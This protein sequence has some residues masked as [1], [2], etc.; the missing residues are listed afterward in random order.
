MKRRVLF[1]TPGCFD[2][3]GISRYCR[4]QIQ[5]LR[6][7]HGTNSVRVL[8]LLGPGENDFEVPF[9]V[10]WSGS[11]APATRRDRVAFTVRAIWTSLMWRPQVVHCAH[12]N[13][14]PLANSLARLSRAETVLNVY[15]LE[16]WSGLSRRRARAMEAFNRVIADCYATADHVVEHGLHDERPTVIWDCADLDRFSPG[17]WSPDVAARYGV[18]ANKEIKVVLFLGRISEASRH[19]GA[20][21]LIAV[22]PRIRRALGAV[23]L[24]MA[25]AGDDKDRLEREVEAKGLEAHIRFTGPVEEQDL[26][27]LYRRADI[28][29]LVS[30]KGPGRGEGIP[31]TPIEALASGVPIVVGDEDGSKEAVDGD[32][33]GLVVSPRVES[34]L[35]RAI[36]QILTEG[37]ESADERRRA[38]RRVAEERFSYDAF[39]QKHR[40]FFRRD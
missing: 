7:I 40:A 3:G 5:A 16:L 30:D 31:L 29:V 4:Y 36:M 2:K 24:V 26:P 37:R 28:F 20:D 33:N 38:A 8:S 6:T 15:G 35:E 32:L 12:V 11:G 22:F 25:G 17:D 13:F 19:K 21:R 23:Q 14:G 9:P 27:D 34:E 10:D 1:L 39:L 18:S